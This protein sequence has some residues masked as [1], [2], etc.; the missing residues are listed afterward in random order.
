[1]GAFGREIRSVSGFVRPETS[2][3]DE[4]GRIRTNPD[5]RTD[6]KTES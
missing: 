2:G 3:P 1:M 5:D 6:E 4:S